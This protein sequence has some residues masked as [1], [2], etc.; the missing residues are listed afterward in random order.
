MATSF[1]LDH[2]MQKRA[3]AKAEADGLSLSAAVR[4]LLAGYV[5][6]RIS[7]AAIPASE[8]VT[9]EKVEEIPMDAKTQKVA[10]RLFAAARKRGA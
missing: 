4:L 3:G 8:A 9:V 7:I 6:G 1:T 2:D 5:S 10:R